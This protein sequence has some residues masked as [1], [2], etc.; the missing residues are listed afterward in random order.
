MKHALLL[1][2][3]EEIGLPLYILKKHA[4]IGWQNV[5]SV[6][7]WL[8]A[9]SNQNGLISATTYTVSLARDLSVR[10]PI[11]SDAAELAY[12]QNAKHRKAH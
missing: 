6:P 10:R 12:A 4:S 9:V 2:N 11:S 3:L 5:T 7:I 8:L 1:C